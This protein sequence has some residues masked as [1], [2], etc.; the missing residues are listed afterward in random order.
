MDGLRAR[1][2]ARWRALRGRRP[3]VRHVADAWQLMQR[4]NGNLYAAAITYFSFLALFPLLLLGVAIVGFALHS[5]PSLQHSLYQHV[6]ER[7]PGRIGSTLHDAIQ[8]AID[9]RSSV[10]VIALLGVL[11][12]GLGWVANL[13]A[14]IDAVWG[15]GERKTGFLQASLSN[16]LVLTGLGIGSVASLA[17]TAIGTSL[18]DQI[19]RYLDLADVT[20]STLL[21]KVLGIALAVAGDTLIFWWLLARLPAVTVPE[22]L[23]WRGALFAAIGFEVLKI[24]GTYIVAHTTGSVT[25]GPFAGLVAI[26]VWMQL[27]ARWLLFACAWTATLTAEATADAPAAAQPHAGGEQEGG[28]DDRGDLEA[29]E[30]PVVRSG[31]DGGRGAVEDGPQ[32]GGP[33]A[34]GLPGGAS[35]R[36]QPTDRL[37]TRG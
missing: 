16:L 3:S 24:L 22:R 4:N 32:P 17:L 5:D 34:G 11:L 37:G 29:M 31:G 7:F 10:G 35:G 30:E 1:W 19:L 2:T 23:A 8:T 13:R 15:L 14:A 20:G 33:A 36:D 9:N 21:M 12:T 28:A 26:L 18:T 25:A 6:A 27:V